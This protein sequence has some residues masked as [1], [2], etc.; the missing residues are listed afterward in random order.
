MK[1]VHI[2]ILIC[3]N[4]T[5]INVQTLTDDTIIALGFDEFLST[6][7]IMAKKVYPSSEN[8]EIAMKQIL[9]DNVLPFASRR[10]PISIKPVIRQPEILSLFNYYKESL[11]ALM[12]WFVYFVYLSL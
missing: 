6:L 8:D 9:M 1:K 12:V 7:V 4:I 11:I 10:S 3:N 5:N 2:H